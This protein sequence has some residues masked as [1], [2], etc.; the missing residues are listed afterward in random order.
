MSNFYIN[1]K[2]K[3]AAKKKSF[4]FY[5]MTVLIIPFIYFLCNEV[6]K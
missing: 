6:Y 2:A 4:G 5:S 1:H 3:E